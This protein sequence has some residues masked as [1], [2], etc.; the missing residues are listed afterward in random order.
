MM[1][2][3]RFAVVVI[4]LFAGALGLWWGGLNDYRETRQAVMRMQQEMD[5]M[6]VHMEESKR[7]LVAVDSLRVAVQSLRGVSDE[8]LFKIS[9][10]F[11][12]SERLEHIE[13]LLE[14]DLARR[15]SY[16]TAGGV[17]GG[18]PEAT[19]TGGDIKSP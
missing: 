8:A 16:N 12:G 3:A 15:N 17:V 2:N 10:D 14:D 6:R 11:Y 13:R 1:A 9:R 19:R 5:T 18:L 7:V 4:I